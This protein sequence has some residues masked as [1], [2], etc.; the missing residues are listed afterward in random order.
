LL[1]DR[2]SHYPDWHQT[3][4]AQ[5]QGELTYPKWFEGSWVATSTLLEQIAPLAPLKHEIC[6]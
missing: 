2:I 6:Q 5:R 4:F 1:S 3:Q